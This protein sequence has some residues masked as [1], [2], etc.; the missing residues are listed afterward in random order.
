MVGKKDDIDFTS[1]ALTTTM[2]ESRI[3]MVIDF[4]SFRIVYDNDRGMSSLFDEVV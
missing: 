2:R 4:C 3:D 1:T